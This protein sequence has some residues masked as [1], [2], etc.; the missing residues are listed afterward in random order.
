MLH[1]LYWSFGVPRLVDENLVVN[2]YYQ[3]GKHVELHIPFPTRSF[4]AGG[5]LQFHMDEEDDYDAEHFLKSNSPEGGIRLYQLLGKEAQSTLIHTF[6]N[7]PDNSSDR[8]LILRFNPPMEENREL[9]LVLED[10]PWEWLHDGESYI[11][12]RYSLQIIRT[13]ARDF[14]LNPERKVYQNS[15]KILLISPFI[16]KNVDYTQEIGLEHLPAAIDE[17]TEIYGLE[18]ATNGLVEVIPPVEHPDSQGIKT[19]AELESSL[20]ENSRSG[21]PILHYVGHGVLYNDEPCLC[22]ENGNGAIDYVT[23]SRLRQLFIRLREKQG[24]DALPAIIFINACSSSSRGRYSSGFAA[25]LHDLGICVIGYSSQIQDDYLTVSAAKNFYQSLCINQALQKPKDPPT[26]HHALEATRRE[27]R[28]QEQEGRQ[29]GNYLRA[30][31]PVEVSYYLQGRTWLERH[32]Q[33]QY[34]HWA[35]WMNPMDYT[36]HLSLGFVFAFLFGLL[37]GL[38]NLFLIFH[39]TLIG[40][41]V[42][43]QEIVSELLRILLVGPLAFH[44]AAFLSAW[45]TRR[46]HKLWITAR[47]K[48]LSQKVFIYCVKS[49][50]VFL[51][52]GGVFSLIFAYSFSRLDV[53][54]AQMVS[55]SGLISVPIPV[56]WYGL[57]AGLGV[58]LALQM[59]LATFLNLRRNA[60]LFSYRTYYV[61]GTVYVLLLVFLILY[62]IQQ[63]RSELWQFMIWF[64]CVLIHLSGYSFLAVKTIKETSFKDS[65]IGPTY[66]QLSV[67]KLLPLVTGVLLIG[68]CYYFLEETVRFDSHIIHQALLERH[69]NPPE[70]QKLENVKIIERALRQ[71]AIRDV[72]GSMQEDAPQDWLLSLVMADYHLYRSYH[73]QEPEQALKWLEQSKLYLRQVVQNHPEIQF[74]DYFRNIYAMVYMMIGDRLEDH[75]QKEHYYEVA[76]NMAREAIGKDEMNFAYLDTLA[77]AEARLAVLKS[78][79]ELLQKAAQ[80][81]REALWRAFFLRSSRAGEV[82]EGIESMADFIQQKQMEINTTPDK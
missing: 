12:R 80:H 57:I 5:S 68:F 71:R 62:W 10:L 66:K 58:F 20:L 19:F 81:N 76:V 65:H 56:F 52:I 14:E 44:V 36:D 7:L 79:P 45:Q 6:A 69:A 11:S 3:T 61:L 4:E 13:H 16:Q 29:L 82:R 8:T 43:Y 26:V 35:K 30:Y 17:V 72:P 75:E 21:T 78:D 70:Y 67:K 22:L 18:N 60:T 1:R 53:L 24:A 73:T 47:E 55:I 46:N 38:Q 32:V 41:Y 28:N 39:E 49:L 74:R 48:D 15:W 40:Q 27:L 77:R 2:F 59:A 37:L 31:F 33:N 25:G 42:T 50:P 64:F 63:T 23:V 34:N 51:L 9:S 54:I